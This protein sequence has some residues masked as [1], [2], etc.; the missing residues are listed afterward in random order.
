MEDVGARLQQRCFVCGQANPRGLRLLF[1]AAEDGGV[2]AEWRP[3]EDLEGF[4]GIIHGGIVSTV[5]D[6][7]MS[8][9]V[10]ASGWKAL[11]CELRVRLRRPVRPGTALR[12][13]ERVTGQRR[14]RISA[15]AALEDARGEEYARAW[16]VFLTLSGKRNSL[17]GPAGFE[18]ATNG[19]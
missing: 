5:L 8:K 10:M 14:R 4:E 1:R 12:V 18:P 16:G 15:E 9:A 11:T 6:E 3:P 19:L 17:V 13:R 2:S 7:A